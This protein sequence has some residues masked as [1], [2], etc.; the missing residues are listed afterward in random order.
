MTTLDILLCESLTKI[1]I[2]VHRRVVFPVTDFIW[3]QCVLTWKKRLFQLQFSFSVYNSQLKLTSTSKTE[4]KN[5]DNPGGTQ[6]LNS[7][8]G[9]EG[10]II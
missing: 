7:Y 3:L 9:V 1:K 8:F 10:S 6:I 5:I 2:S 4:A